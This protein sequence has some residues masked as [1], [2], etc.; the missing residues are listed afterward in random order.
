[1]EAKGVGTLKAMKMYPDKADILI[2]QAKRQVNAAKGTPIQWHF[3]EK[4]AADT[5]KGMLQK[6]GMSDKIDVIHTPMDWSK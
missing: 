2:E 3:A 4:E 5:F 6:I 1:M